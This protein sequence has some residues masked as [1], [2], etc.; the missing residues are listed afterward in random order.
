[1][2]AVRI[3]E[4]GAADKLRYEEVGEPK[5]TDPTDVIV[6]LKAAAL[7]HI[8]IWNRRGLPGIEISLPRILG[9]DG[10]GIVIEV[11]EQARNVKRGDAVCL[12]PP[13]GCSRCE[14][15]L[16]DRDFMCLHLRALG[17]RLEG[18]YA[19]YVKL[20]AKNCFPIPPGLSFE[21]AASFPLV[22]LTVWRMLVTNAQIK[23]GEHVLVLGVGGGVAS[24]ALQVAKHMGAHVIVT[25]SSDEKLTMAK[26][27][28]ADHGINYV[29]SDFAKEVRALTGKRGVEIVVDSVGGE[30]WSKS[31]GALAKGGRLV[32]CGATAGEHP[33][34]DIPRIFWN[35]LKIFGSTLGSREEFRQILNFMRTSQLRPIIDHLFPLKEVADAH[36]RLEEGKQFGKIV[37][38]VGE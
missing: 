30:S 12:Y 11:G 2:K 23:P 5:L 37:L 38:Q 33:S 29:K 14:F 8:D 19:E 25:S 1:M 17:E 36:R 6:Q 15:C 20:P 35:H 28:G 3:H 22:F 4:H 18:T 10:A 21:E 26:N 34:T 24:A 9:A 31:L 27:W 13:T 32:T 16:T 7:N